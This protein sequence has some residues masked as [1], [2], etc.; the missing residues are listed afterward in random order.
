MQLMS[1]AADPTTGKPG[2]CLMGFQFWAM[3][4]WTSIIGP[5]EPHPDNGLETA[6]GVG[7]FQFPAD[8]GGP[9]GQLNGKQFGVTIA[10][11]ALVF[12]FTDDGHSTAPNI[13]VTIAPGASASACATAAANAMTS[14]FAALSIG[15]VGGLSVAAIA[16]IHPGASDTVDVH[17]A[18]PLVESFEVAT[19]PPTPIIVSGAPSVSPNVFFAQGGRYYGSWLRNAMKTFVYDGADQVVPSNFPDLRNVYAM[20]WPLRVTAAGPRCFPAHVVP[21]LLAQPAL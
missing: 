19:I 6:Y 12:E 18:A 21:Y 13:A 1:L 7:S 5:V 14:A 17:V 3:Q 2:P 9:P 4:H 11:K 15:P 10:G 20:V 8:S 16:S